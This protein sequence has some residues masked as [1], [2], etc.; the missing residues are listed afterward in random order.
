MDHTKRIEQYI[1][2]LA[3]AR[4]QMFVYIITTHAINV[5]FFLMGRFLY[6]SEQWHVLFNFHCHIIL[7]MRNKQ[8]L[9]V[10]WPLSEMVRHLIHNARIFFILMK[11]YQFKK[12]K[13]IVLVEMFIKFVNMLLC[14]PAISRILIHLHT[15]TLS[16][17]VVSRLQHVHT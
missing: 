9:R 11:L 17:Y 3:P 5:L 2:S 14:F 13:G 15:I 8:V 10:F 6:F 4:I 7:N 1:N 16:L 12:K